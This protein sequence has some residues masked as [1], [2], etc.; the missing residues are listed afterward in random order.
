MPQSMQWERSSLAAF[1]QSWGG[2]IVV[3]NQATSGKMSLFPMRGGNPKDQERHRREVKTRMEKP[4]IGQIGLLDQKLGHEFLCLVVLTFPLL[5]IF[6]LPFLPFFWF[7]ISF[8][9]FRF[10]FLL[11][12]FLFFSFNITL[13]CFVFFPSVFHFCDMPQ[14]WYHTHNK[15]PYMANVQPSGNRI[16]RKYAVLICEN[17]CQTKWIMFGSWKIVKKKYW[18]KF[19][20]LFKLNEKCLE[21]ENVQP[22]GQLGRHCK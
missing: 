21:P 3:E 15:W 20:L 22:S 11:L 17:W 18:E 7:S 12:V 1:V 10:F 5:L 13:L 14:N 9:Y 2:F 4:K 8:L 6:P 16:N 19:R